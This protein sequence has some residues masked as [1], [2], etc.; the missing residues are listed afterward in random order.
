MTSD[1]ERSGGAE[2]TP[3]AH[4]RTTTGAVD[5]PG[6]TATEAEGGE[7]SP[8]AVQEEARTADHAEG[9]RDTIDESLRQKGLE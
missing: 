4:S 1:S 8:Q 5:E 3:G 2:G 9:D 7:E 6:R